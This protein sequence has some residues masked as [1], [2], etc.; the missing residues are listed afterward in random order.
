MRD[1]RRS[2]GK[3]RRKRAGGAKGNDARGKDG[4]YTVKS[5]Q[6]PSPT[7][8]RIPKPPS[9][10]GK[11]EQAA[12]LLD[13]PSDTTLSSFDQA[14]KDTLKGGPFWALPPHYPEHRKCNK[15]RR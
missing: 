13:G 8:N 7:Q 10:N 11:A 2:Q 5:R 1:S 9:S 4:Q 3:V 6:P 12:G 15:K 14:G